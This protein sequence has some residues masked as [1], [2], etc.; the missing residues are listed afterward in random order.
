MYHRLPGNEVKLKQQTQSDSPIGSLSVQV[1]LLS[2]AYP[3]RRQ[4]DSSDKGAPFQ[5]YAA[6]L[7]LLFSHPDLQRDYS[8]SS[9]PRRRN[10][11][12]SHQRFILSCVHSGEVVPDP[13]PTDQTVI[14]STCSL[15]T[16]Y[17]FLVPFK[18]ESFAPSSSTVPS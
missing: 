13:E 8:T 3:A 17:R 9:Y 18:I 15:P 5:V 12:R 7:S 6:G 4:M 14:L 1:S 11:L 10:S 16:C 2:A